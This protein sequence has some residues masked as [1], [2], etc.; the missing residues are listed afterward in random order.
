LNRWGFLFAVAASVL[1]VILSTL[2]LAY[3]RFQTGKSLGTDIPD[4][5]LEYVAKAVEIPYQ[6]VNLAFTDIHYFVKASTT[7][8]ELELLKGVTGYV[9]AGKM[10]ALMGSR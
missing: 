4:A 5:P 2:F 6:K 1:S 10:T 7:D 3:W 9:E 8:E